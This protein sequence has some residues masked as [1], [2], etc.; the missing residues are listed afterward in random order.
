[1]A[2]DKI[3][4]SGTIFQGTQIRKLLNLR[5]TAFTVETDGETVTFHTRGFGHRVGM[6]QY[7]AEAMAV[8]GS[9]YEDILYHYYQ[10]TQL[11]QYVIDKEESVG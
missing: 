4:I 7:G 3:K 1:M 8:S 6:S 2:V 9:N 10:G 11:Q 5:S